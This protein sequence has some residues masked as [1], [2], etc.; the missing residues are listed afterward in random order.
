MGIITGGRVVRQKRAL[1]IDV[2]PAVGPTN[3][4]AITG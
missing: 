2:L 1:I 4:E 3:F